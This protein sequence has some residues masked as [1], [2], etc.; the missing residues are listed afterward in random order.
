MTIDAERRGDGGEIPVASKYAHSVS[1][2]TMPPSHSL[3]SGARKSSRSVE[4]RSGSPS[5]TPLGRHR[6]SGR[7]DCSPG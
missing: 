1:R 2:R 7:D 4:T 6:R 3:S 5:T